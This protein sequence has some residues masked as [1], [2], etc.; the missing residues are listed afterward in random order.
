MHVYTNS[1]NEWKSLIVACCSRIFQEE[2]AKSYDE[3]PTGSG[4][5]GFEIAV[6]DTE[7]SVTA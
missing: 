2:S 3:T 1:Q 4:T 7:A 6:E 5:S